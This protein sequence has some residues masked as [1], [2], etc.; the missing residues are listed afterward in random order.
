M[1]SFQDKI[2]Y[3]PTVRGLN[4]GVISKEEFDR[5]GKRSPEF[6]VDHD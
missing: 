3:F 6:V 5:V 1:K 4:P 2:M